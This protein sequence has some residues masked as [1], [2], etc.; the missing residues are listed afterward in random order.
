MLESNFIR[1]KRKDKNSKESRLSTNFYN[2][3][4]SKEK[5][6]RSKWKKRSWKSNKNAKKRKNTF[7]K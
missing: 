3:K 7:S 6:M 5:S 2:I 4:R 1:N